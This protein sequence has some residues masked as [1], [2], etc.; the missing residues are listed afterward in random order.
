LGTFIAA[1]FSGL[2][3]V[4]SITVLIGLSLLR[5]EPK[6]CRPRRL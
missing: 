5:L 6:G 1:V 3:L 2:K 4:F